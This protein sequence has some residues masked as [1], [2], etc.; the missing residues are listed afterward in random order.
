[1]DKDNIVR[2]TTEEEI[3]QQVSN[4]FAQNPDPL[5]YKVVIE[6]GNQQIVLD[7]DIDLGGGFESGYETT[8]FTAPL[9]ASTDFRFAIHQ[10]HFTDEIGK[11][12]GMQ[13]VEIGYEEFDKK[14]IIKTNDKDKVRNVFADPSVRTVIQNLENFTFA[15]TT[16]HSSAG[17]ENKPFLELIIET[18]ITD[19]DKLRSIYSAYHFVLTKLES[20]TNLTT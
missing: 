13:D 17:A 3:W 16:H 15:I 9:H 20:A 8:S 1:M 12:F 4:Q 7:I 6:H 14:V 2:G 18:G 11:F 10:E 19:L 5:E